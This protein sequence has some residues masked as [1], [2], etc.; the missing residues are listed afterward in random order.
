MV[1]VLA[2][3]TAGEACQNSLEDGGRIF[4]LSNAGKPAFSVG[5][6][7]THVAGVLSLLKESSEQSAVSC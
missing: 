7:G 1:T 5:E 3:L 4:I 6:S 2:S